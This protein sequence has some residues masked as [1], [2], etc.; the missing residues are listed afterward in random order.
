MSIVTVTLN[1]CI[2]K[3]FS[4]ERVIP[5]RKLDGRE[6]QCF[7]G[8]GGINVTRVARRLGARAHALW[9]SGGNVGRVLSELLDAEGV[10]HTPVAIEG[11]VRENLIVRDV[12]CNHQYRFGMP[13]P[14]L[15]EDERNRWVEEVRRH[16]ASAD[17]LVLSGSLPPSVP[18]TWFA[19]LI[20]AAA[21]R[22][23]VVVDTKK[24][25]LRQ[26]LDAGVYLIKPNVRELEELLGRELDDD[27]DIAEA[28]RDLIERG[29]AE[30]M[31]VSLGR[32]GAL[33]ATGEGALRLS[34]PAVPIRSKV[35]A[36]DSM[37]GGLIAALDRGSSMAEAARLAVA[38][39][40][41][42]VLSS[43]TELARREDVERLH[44][45]V[46]NP[47]QLG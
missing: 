9:S 11:A 2:D 14:D 5:E 45:R 10:E 24:E 46:E 17:F 16:T 21:E 7:P 4:V 3:T 47:E 23:R 33:L 12:S 42:A 1:P 34:A 44:A 31:L 41:A 40:A 36:G 20:R 13:G 37:V 38:A 43:G 22:T 35:G 18:P 19:E 32:G 30:A 27:H 25:P 15:T 8:G 28:A 29:A 26:A 6:V 39:G